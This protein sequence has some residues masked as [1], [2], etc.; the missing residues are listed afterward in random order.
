MQA[1]PSTGTPARL[2]QQDCFWLLLHWVVEGLLFLFGMAAAVAMTAEA[3]TAMM[4]DGC[5]F[6][7]ELWMRVD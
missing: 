3:R 7:A 5:I 6:L 4:V 2:L 1:D